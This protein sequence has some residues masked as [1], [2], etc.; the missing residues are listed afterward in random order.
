MEHL[1][2]EGGLVIFNPVA[3][4]GQGAKRKEEAQAHLGPAFEWVP[5]QRP[6]HAIELA[7]AGAKKH[8]VVVA[9]GG[10]GTVGDVMRGILQAKADGDS[11]H[12]ATL[13]IIPVGTGNDMARNLKLVLETR[14][15]C[16]TILGGVTK[17]IDVGMINGTPFINNAGT[18]FDAAVM[19]TMNT[20]IKFVSGQLAFRLA[21]FKTLAK[22]KPFALTITADDG[23]KRQ[24]RAFM[25][26]VLNGKVYAA[27]MEAAPHAEV[28][29]GRLDVMIIKEMSK[30]KLIPVIQLVAS[31]QH[32]NHPAVEML[33]VRK[34]EVG[35]I[36]P[37]PLNIDG[38]VRG[39]TPMTIE[40]RPRELKVLVR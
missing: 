28:D 17:R 39:L 18:G 15:A 33:Q 32:L 5:T 40:V 31:G 12:E 25:V 38:E 34:L 6:G 22:Y 27:G 26:S 13:G 36:P 30:L 23:E 4:R 24:L 29:D 35:T 3:G 1:V 10:D 7:R 14:E 16:A 20:S 9:F 8:E 37:Q 2:S 21:I 11:P 19:H